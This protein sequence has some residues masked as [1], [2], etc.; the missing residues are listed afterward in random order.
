VL[1]PL[2]IAVVGCLLLLAA[3]TVALLRDKP[4]NRDLDDPDEPF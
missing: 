3:T 4:W 1:H 2:G